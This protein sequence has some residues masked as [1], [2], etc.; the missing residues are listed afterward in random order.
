[1]VQILSAAVLL[2]STA[3]E[4]QACPYQETSSSASTG[5][6]VLVMID[7]AAATHCAKG[8]KLVGQNCSYTTGMVARRV[9]EEGQDWSWAGLLS[10]AHDDLSSQVA[11]PFVADPGTRIIANELVEMLASAGHAH[12]RLALTGKLLDVDGVRYVVLTSYKVDN[13]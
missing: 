2:A 12:D 5:T 4:A 7:A 3:N 6:P 13:S 11:A 9:V 10:D 1:M 8:D